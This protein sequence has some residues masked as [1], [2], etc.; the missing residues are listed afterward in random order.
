MIMMGI[1]KEFVIE[2][3]YSREDYRTNH[4]VYKK[5]KPHARDQIFADAA[6]PVD[7]ETPSL[8]NQSF[9]G[10]PQSA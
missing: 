5:V 3:K 1:L 4:Q 8:Q 6:V 10:L 7:S 2:I 9:N